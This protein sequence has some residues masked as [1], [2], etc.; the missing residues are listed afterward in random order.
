M[1]GLF[2]SLKNCTDV[3]FKFEAKMSGHTKMQI[4]LF[5]GVIETK[6][7]LRIC[8]CFFADVKTPETVAKMPRASCLPEAENPPTLQYT[9]IIFHIHTSADM[10]YYTI[11]MC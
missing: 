6:P 5:T 8:F 7:Y 1:I 10:K 3:L 11:Y 9:C 4:T 2:I